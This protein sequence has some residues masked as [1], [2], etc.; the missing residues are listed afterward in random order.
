MLSKLSK[1]QA[2]LLLPGFGAF[3]KK[4]DFARTTENLIVFSTITLVSV[5]S[6]YNTTPDIAAPFLAYRLQHTGS[7]LPA[8]AHR[9]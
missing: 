4:M 6:R 9:F 2:T 8:T 5:A 1:A 7:S 3:D